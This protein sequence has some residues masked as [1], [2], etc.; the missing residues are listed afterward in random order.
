MPSRAWILLRLPLL[1]GAGAVLALSARG[2]LTDALLAWDGVRDWVKHG[3]FA[4]HALLLHAP[5]DGL[6]VLALA[7]AAALPA[8]PRLLPAAAALV[9]GALALAWGGAHPLAWLGWAA[10]VVANLA[11]LR[12]LPARALRVPGVEVV[13]PLPTLRA[14]VPSPGPLA[15]AAATVPAALLFVLADAGL[16]AMAYEDAVMD[17]PDALRAPEV[18]VLDRSRFG[19]R[20]DFHDLDLVPDGDGVR[21]VVVQENARRLSSYGRDPGPLDSWELPPWWTER[22]GLVMDSETDPAT[23]TTWFL[24]GARQVTALRWVAGRWEKVGRSTPLPIPYTHAYTRHLPELGRVV[25]VSVNA[26]DPA[27][28][29]IV[30]TLRDTDL[31][32]VRA[33]EPLTADRRPLPT[34]RE[35][36]W[37]PTVRKL[38]LA[39]DFGSRLFLVDPETLRAEKWVSLPAMDGKMEWL[40]SLGRLAVASPA[41]GGVWLLDPAS[42]QPDRLLP[43]QPGVRAFA[44]DEARGLLV[45]ASVLTG[46]IEVRRLDGAV[47]RRLGTIMPMVRELRLWPATGEVFVTSW[48]R[49]Y[50]ARYTEA[51]LP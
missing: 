30:T 25:L 11:P 34:I 29:P 48:S 26:R 19:A 45:T 14:L 36:A 21:A 5:R 39:P 3:L 4:W 43:T 9:L 18:E 37:I 6:L 46:Q 20:S 49:L 27:L 8:R 12:S 32:V 35:V 1:L 33:G 41:Q 15:R 22:N 44:V 10:L 28:H 42:D 47:E 2:A 16:G 23:G 40:P 50:R 38:A 31:V 51:P 17:W 13:L 7:L 24:D